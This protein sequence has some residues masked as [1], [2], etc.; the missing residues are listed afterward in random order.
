M[1][2]ARRSI[3]R[4][5]HIA[6]SRLIAR[7]AR[8][9]PAYRPKSPVRA[10]RCDLARGMLNRHAPMKTIQP[11]ITAALTPR[12]A[13]LYRAASAA[14]G[15]SL[16]WAGCA[17]PSTGGQATVESDAG[18]DARQPPAS[19]GEGASGVDGSSRLPSACDPVPGNPGDAGATPPSAGV[20]ML[21]PST[22][23][24]LS[25]GEPRL[26]PGLCTDAQRAAFFR[27]CTSEQ[28]T[29]STCDSFVSAPANKPCVECLSGPSAAPASPAASPVPA[30]LFVEGTVLVQ[31]EACA[32]VVAGTACCAPLLALDGVCAFTA[33]SLCESAD[34]ATCSAEAANGPCATEHRS[35]AACAS[36]VQAKRSTWDA[37]C[38]GKNFDEIADRV[39]K[40]LC[41]TP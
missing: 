26:R 3:G 6:A 20:C 31:Q 29:T 34:L 37:S 14:F 18:A 32:A 19:E 7:C 9:T 35:A 30:L 1:Q 13:G 11:C 21:S 2:R 27:A 17:S 4:I 25:R 39:T 41:G 5:V 12:R 40:T 15:L 10:R 16:L 22:A 24:L 23:E 33:C 38:G 8:N 28:S 36:L